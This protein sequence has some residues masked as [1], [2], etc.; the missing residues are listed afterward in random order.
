MQQNSV[1]EPPAIVNAGGFAEATLGAPIGVSPDS[2][3]W[4]RIF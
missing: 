1:Y 3:G 4:F 2:S